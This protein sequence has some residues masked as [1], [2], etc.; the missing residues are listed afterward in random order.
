MSMKKVQALL[1]V[2][3]VC[4][5]ST[6]IAADTPHVHTSP[7]L[8]HIYGYRWEYIATIMVVSAAGYLAYRRYAL[9]AQKREIVKERLKKRLEEFAKKS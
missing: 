3:V 2:A 8:D 1:F 7:V 9:Q 5:G 6:S 4:S